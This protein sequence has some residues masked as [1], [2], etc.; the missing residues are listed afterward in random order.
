MT[1]SVK[2]KQ[3]PK[4][5]SKPKTWV[6]LQYERYSENM[7]NITPIVGLPFLALRVQR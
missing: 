5:Q 4:Y 6:V 1:G 3:E 2:K 7:T